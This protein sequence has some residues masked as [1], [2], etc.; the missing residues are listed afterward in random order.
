MTDDDLPSRRFDA[1]LHVSRTGAWLNGR[2]D[3]S[4]TRLREELDR[5]RVTRGCLV[6]LPGVVDN[7]YLLECAAASRGRLVPIAGVD[8]RECT[9]GEQ[10]GARATALAKAGFL[11]IK[12]HPRLGGYDPLDPRALDTIRAAGDAGMVVFLDTLF[13]QRGRATPCAADVIDRMVTS[14]PGVRIVLLHGGGTEILDVAQVVR[15]HEN[16]LLD[17]SYTLIAFAGSSV[18]LDLAWVL[19]HLDRRVVV[20]S[21]MP[22]YTPS[23]AFGRVEDLMRDLPPVKRAN[24]TYENLAAVFGA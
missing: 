7:E 20:G 16:L 8:P 3:A 5:G 23:E 14:C 15:I 21:D 12:L 4:V 1:L 22:E 2:D 11:G 13:R 10:A 24:V 9:S 19:R 18:D 6:G 17:L